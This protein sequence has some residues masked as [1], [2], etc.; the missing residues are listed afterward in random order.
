MLSFSLWRVLFSLSHL[1]DSLLSELGPSN[2]SVSSFCPLLSPY[3]TAIAFF[4]SLMRAFTA[5]LPRLYFILFFCSGATQRIEGDVLRI[6]RGGQQ[7]EPLPAPIS[8]AALIS[9][10][11]P[12]AKLTTFLLSPGIIHTAPQNRCGRPLTKPLRVLPSAML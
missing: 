6:P 2:F 8:G 10:F 1:S 12:P 7:A 11:L 4:L 9:Y 3:Y 5:F